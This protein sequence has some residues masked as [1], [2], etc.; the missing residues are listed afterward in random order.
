[1]KDSAQLDK[2]LRYLYASLVYLEVH[3]VAIRFEFNGETWEADTAEE[4]IA[5]RAKLEYSTRFPRD[6]HKEMDEESRFWT[7]DRFTSVIDN[8]GK[9]QH[10][11][12][13]LIWGQY[14]IS[15]AE[16]VEKLGLESEVALAGVISGLSKQLKQLGI[17]PKQVFIIDVKW[18]GKKKTRTFKLNDFFKGVGQEHNWPDVWAKEVM[19]N[20]ARRG[21]AVP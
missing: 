11:F 15:S 10:K 19:G 16:L 18:N 4:A 5:L 20:S 3:L 1:M 14:G 13:M 8:I 7:P 6:P 21:K 2:A 12:L 17:E 9:L